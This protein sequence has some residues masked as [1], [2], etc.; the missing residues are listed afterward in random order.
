MF[1][2]VNPAEKL[3]INSNAIFSL[4]PNSTNRNPRSALGGTKKNIIV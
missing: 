2:M 4:F 1:N 3:N